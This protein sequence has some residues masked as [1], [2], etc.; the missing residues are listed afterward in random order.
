MREGKK[1][2]QVWASTEKCEEVQRSQLPNTYHKQYLHFIHRLFLQ[3][4]IK[5]SLM[6]F[7]CILWLWCGLS[8][9]H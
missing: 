9:K 8:C 5:S 7:V 3:N 2:W 6:R 4:F 1:Y